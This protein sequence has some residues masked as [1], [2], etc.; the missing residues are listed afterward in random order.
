MH[1][2]VILTSLLFLTGSSIASDIRPS[3]SLEKS[4]P[5]TVNIIA[6]KYDVK[7][8]ESEAPCAYIEP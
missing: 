5:A 8:S 7:V 1:L 2:L 6:H 3:N 4:F